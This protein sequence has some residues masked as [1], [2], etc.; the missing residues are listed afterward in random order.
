VSEAA[1]TGRAVPARPPRDQRL[2]ALRGLLQIT[3]FLG[4]AA[5]IAPGS[6]WLGGWIIHTAWGFSDSSEQFIFTSGLGLGSVFTL[7]FLRDGQAAAI[8][9]LLRRALRLYRTH[10]VMMLAFG[11]LILWA[12][13]RPQFPDEIDRMGWRLVTE[14]PWLALALTPPMIFQ[15]Q[16]MEILPVFVVCTLMVAPFLLLVERIGDAALLL[17]VALYIATPLVGLALPAIGPDG[18]SE[19]GLN[20][21]S[22][23]LLY[24]LG[25]WLGRRSLLT[26]GRAVPHSRALIAASIGFLVWGFFVRIA[27]YGWWPASLLPG[28][29]IPPLGFVL[30]E[31]L[32]PL[33]LLHGLALAYLAVVLLP[34]QGAA[35]TSGIGPWLMATGRQ[36]LLA[37]CLG[38]FLSWAVSAGLRV[39]G[40]SH[41]LDA[42]LL[43]LGALLLLAWGGWLERGS[44]QVSVAGGQPGG[45]D[46]R[47]G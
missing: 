45:G 4:H 43:A 39:L 6:S 17:P 41:A 2:D 24:L 20:P 1:A 16:F 27:T 25:A 30:K 8:A 33:R 29:W 22:W 9:D 31:T 21:F 47:G 36:S 38:L 28:G 12:G 42:A 7:K 5:L 37:Y 18:H 35:Y 11:G 10:L 40:Y 46:R 14:R 26:G 32:G 23:Q 34:R 19:F 44:G 3:I 13:T 15:P